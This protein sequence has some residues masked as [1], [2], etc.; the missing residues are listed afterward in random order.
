MKLIVL[1]CLSP[2]KV[3]AFN[4]NGQVRGFVVAV[5]LLP[6]HFQKYKSFSAISA[7]SSIQIGKKLGAEKI[8]VGGMITTLAEKAGLGKNMVLKSLTAQIFWHRLRRKRYHNCSKNKK[9]LSNPSVL[10][11]QPRRQGLGSR[12]I[13]LPNI[14]RTPSIRQDGCK[15]RIACR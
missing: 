12:D 6:V 5:P 2:Y 3:S 4:D 11:V 10:L 8:S 15:C 13:F 14:S 7:W 1:M 9:R